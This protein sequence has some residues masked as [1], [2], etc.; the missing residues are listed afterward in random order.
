MFVVRRGGFETRPHGFGKDPETL[1]AEM[2]IPDSIET[3]LTALLSDIPDPV[4]VISRDFQILW[5]NNTVLDYVQCE[6]DRIRGRLCYRVLF[7]TR[8][9]CVE[10]PVNMVFHAG[11]A[12]VL[13]KCFTDGVGSVMWREVRAYPVRDETGSIVAAIRIGFDITD[14]KR[15]RDRQT[16]QVEE[17]ERA[18]RALQ[19]AGTDAPSVNRESRDAYV[20]TPREMHVLRLLTQGLTNRQISGILCISHNT[21]K[22]HVAHIYN[23]LGV[24]RRAEA[25]AKAL[26]LGLL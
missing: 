21:V 20:L 11:R 19:E 3:G 9:R 12:A 25:A 22:S 26:R 10:C 15:L 5:A 6:L 23:K 24:I 17:L 14:K 13:E 2:T 18:L 4:S 16:S 1:A 7:G 8:Q